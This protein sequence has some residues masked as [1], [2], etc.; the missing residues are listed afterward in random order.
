MRAI[1]IV[2]ALFAARPCGA[3]ERP[4]P[5][6]ELPDPGL[7]ARE[8][9]PDGR[10]GGRFGVNGSA[11]APAIRSPDSG[12][13]PELDA[14]FAREEKKPRRSFWDRLLGREPATGPSETEPRRETGARA[15][16]RSGER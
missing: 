16:S 7:D 14:I 1:W 12:T 2:L 4:A 11:D 13:T 5:S 8:P 10:V 9:A 15:S 6:N 3:S